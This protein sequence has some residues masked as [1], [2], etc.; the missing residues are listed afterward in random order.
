LKKKIGGTDYQVAFANI[1]FGVN[2]GRA[3]VFGK[4][5][6]PQI[7]ADGNRKELYFSGYVN[8]SR[9]GGVI[10]DGKL[11]LIGDDAIKSSGDWS[12]VLNGNNPSRPSKIDEQTYFK[13]DCSGFVEIGIKGS[14]QL[15]KDVF[16]PIANDF[17]LLTDPTQ[18]ST[19]QVNVVATSFSNILIDN[20][21]FS[22]PFTLNKVK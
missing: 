7:N 11:Q 18:R 3:R 5:I 9:V 12:L 14:V 2:G 19:A 4:T 10:S 21:K 6:L 15:S 16:I 22:L 1:E 8:L 17:K 13:F 20:L